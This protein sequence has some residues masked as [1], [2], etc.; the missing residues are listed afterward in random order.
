M[1]AAS[2]TIDLQ[3]KVDNVQLSLSLEIIDYVTFALT[4]QLTTRHALCGLVP[5]AT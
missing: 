1:M 5:Y 4:L 2:Q 3:S